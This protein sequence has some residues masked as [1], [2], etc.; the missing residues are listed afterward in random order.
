LRAIVIDNE[1]SSLNQLKK[2]AGTNDN[3][4]LIASFTDSLEGLL[5]VA[6][7]KP[8]VVFIDID[9]P[10]TNGIYMAEQIIKSYPDTCIVFVASHDDYALKAFE[11]NAL[12]YLL[13][14]VTRER[15]CQCVEKL[16][17][18]G[19]GNIDARSFHDLNYHFNESSKKLFIEFEGETILIKPEDIY[20]FEV[21]D[22]TVIIKTKINT[23]T[24]SHPL[25]YYETKLKNYNFYRCH[26]AYLV[27]LDKVSRFI[28]YSKTRR[29]VGFDDMK[30][31]V[32]VSKHNVNAI[33]NLLKF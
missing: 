30:D 6:K 23:Y 22:K 24:S 9:M 3:I 10:E 27:N 1:K 16:L 25:K 18:Y 28:H 32:P 15:F 12:D 2:L 11:L 26:R 17:K 19:G 29:D 8:N 31:T 20:Y 13:K 7:L 14:P 33:Q 4:N 21:R 5:N